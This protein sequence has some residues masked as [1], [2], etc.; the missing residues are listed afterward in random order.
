MSDYIHFL[1][2]LKFTGVS[3]NRWER[4]FDYPATGE[5]IITVDT[6]TQTIDYPKPITLGDRTTSN[7]DHL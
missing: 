2:A 7:F 1:E 5:Y 3:D 4:R 6:G